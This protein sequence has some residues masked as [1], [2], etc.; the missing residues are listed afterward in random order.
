VA[1]IHGHARGR[2]RSSEYRSWHAM[3]DRCH[4]EKHKSYPRY[5]GRGIKVFAEWHGPG[6]FERFLAYIGPK[7]TPRHTI[8]RY[9]DKAGNYEPGNVRWAT[10]KE[11][12]NNTATNRILTWNGRTQTVTQWAREYGISTMALVGRLNNGWP[13]GDALTMPVRP[14]QLEYTI[15]FQGRS[16]TP[17]Q[18]ATE[19]GLSMPTLMY[20]IRSG[21][22]LERALS[23]T[24]DPRGRKPSEAA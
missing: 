2:F 4:R 7:P 19:L 8:D 17:S 18:W 23:T 14:R 3:N 13:T 22:P 24:R 21:W 6:G 5:G 12:S 10:P 1:L 11:Q 16:M 9:P 20:R 15:S